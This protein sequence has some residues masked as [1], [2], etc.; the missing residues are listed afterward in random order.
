[1]K[2]KKK[3]REK[4]VICALMCELCAPG[5]KKCIGGTSS[6]MPQ[7]MRIQDRENNKFLLFS[8]A[9]WWKKRKLTWKSTY[10]YNSSNL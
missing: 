10:K 7:A 9:G 1:M 2:K 5:V 4:E 8:S 3:T 6:V